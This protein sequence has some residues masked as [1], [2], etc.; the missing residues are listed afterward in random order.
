MTLC[1]VKE[2]GGYLTVPQGGKSYRYCWLFRSEHTR[3]HVA[4]KRRGSKS[5]L[6]Y[7]SGDKLR[8][9]LQTQIALSLLQDFYEN[10][11]FR[12]KLCLRSKLHKFNL[13]WLF[14]TNWGDTCCDKSRRVYCS[15][16]ACLHGGGGPQV[17][18]VTCLGGLKKKLTTLPSRGALSQDYWMVAKHVNKKNVGKPHV[19]AINAPQH[20][21]AALAATF[22]AVFFLLLSW[23]VME[24][25]RQSVFC[26]NL[27]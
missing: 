7:R 18:G 5:P 8:D 12:D 19:L 24:S 13:I 14:S 11:C 6:V 1:P 4:A 26:A 2:A 21:L 25:H 27:I 9:R 15:L 20:S 10:F 17:G 23:I 3:R 16:R 22:S